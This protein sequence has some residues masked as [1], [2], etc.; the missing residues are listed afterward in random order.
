MAGMLVDRHAWNVSLIR[1]WSD[2]RGVQYQRRHGGFAVVGQTYEEVHHQEFIISHV[3]LDR[4]DR[5]LGAVLSRQQCRTPTID[6]CYFF[7]CQVG[8]E[9][10]NYPGRC[11]TVQNCVQLNNGLAYR[12]P[13]G[14]ECGFGGNS[15]N[16]YITNIGQFNLI[17]DVSTRPIEA[18]AVK[19]RANEIN[20][21][22]VMSKLQH[23]ACLD[24]ANGGNVTVTGTGGSVWMK[25]PSA[26]GR[27]DKTITDYADEWYPG[28][29]A[30][31]SVS[32][33]NLVSNTILSIQN[34]ISTIRY[35]AYF[36]K[37]TFD[38]T[39]TW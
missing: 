34:P 5:S 30:V 14:K 32:N 16:I 2:R 37:M 18:H 9:Y 36:S 26:S 8:V 28:A 33:K 10:F 19:C 6:N 12:A 3:G 39:C 24:M 27:G 4:G 38:G 25:T 35:P 23:G 21:T 31:Y 17:R 15:H 1:P 20:M 11:C 13:S 7:G 22:D 29:D